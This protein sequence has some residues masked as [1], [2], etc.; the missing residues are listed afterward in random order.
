M[1]KFI[2][3]L[4]IILSFL[5]CSSMVLANS[6]P[7][8]DGLIADNEESESS[9]DELNSENSDQSS[10][11]DSGN[12]DS[13]GDSSDGS[14]S[15]NSDQSSDN[16]SGNSDSSGDSS[17]ESLGGN[18][19]DVSWGQTDPIGV[20]T[21]ECKTIF[22]NSD[23]TFNAFG[24][25]V[26]DIF[27]LLKFAAPVMVFAF[28][29]VDYVKAISAQNADEIKKANGRFIKRLVAGIA[30]FF[31]PFILDFIFDIFGLYG[32]DTCGIR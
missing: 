14:N 24:E 26:Q 12:S 5:I 25:F 9:S 4:F 16:N 6:I 22:K 1:K 8:Q 7:L 31:L 23:G 15:E 32:L 2:C 29:T 20:G 30:V 3:L 17:D 10:D 13:S 21:A 18:Q 19:F 27:T 28:S 11:N